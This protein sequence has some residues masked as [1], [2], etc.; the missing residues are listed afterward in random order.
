MEWQTR[1]FEGR[2][3]QAVRVQVPPSAPNST[4]VRRTGGPSVTPADTARS[5]QYYLTAPLPSDRMHPDRS[6]RRPACCA[7][8]SQDRR[9]CDDSSATDKRPYSTRA[10]LHFQLSIISNRLLRLGAMMCG[11]QAYSLDGECDTSYQMNVPP[12]QSRH[13]SRIH[14]W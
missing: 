13:P 3:A 4:V 9:L 11:V 10:Q 7:A 5:F 2:V 1:T 14:A 12:K 8:T 6:L